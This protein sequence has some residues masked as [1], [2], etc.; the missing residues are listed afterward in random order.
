MRL[1]RLAHSL[2][3]LLAQSL[4]YS[5]TEHDAVPYI[6]LLG[7]RTTIKAYTSS[8]SYVT[9]ACLNKLYDLGKVVSVASGWSF[10]NT[11]LQNKGVEV[12]PVQTIITINT[13]TTVST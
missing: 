7:E 10:N 2:I 1:R 11:R 5:L 12:R 8:F 13:R 3:R 6:E 9:S 4:T